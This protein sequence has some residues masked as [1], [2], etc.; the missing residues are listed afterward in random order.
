MNIKRFYLFFLFLVVFGLSKSF[1]QYSFVLKNDTLVSSKEYDFDIFIKSINGTINL[2]SYQIILAVNDSVAKQGN[3]TFNYVSGSSQLL[4]I[5]VVGVGLINDG[6]SYNLTIGSNHGSDTISTGYVKVGRFRIFSTSPFGDYKADL[7]W[8]FNGFVKSEININDT[9][10]TNPSNYINLLTNPQLVITGIKNKKFSPSKFE[11]YPNYPNPF[12]PTTNI[13]FSLPQSGKVMLNIYN[14][15]GQ[16]I[17]VLIDGTLSAG[18]HTVRFDGSN[19]ASGTY[20]YL[21][22]QDNLTKVRKMIL[23]K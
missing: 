4:N 23:V 21:L 2:T 6:T 12:N 5:P 18:D 16:K 10:K 19:F 22:Q 15:L 17:E 1:A 13:K 20:I 9:N 14:I 8:D 3:L 7:D 11:L